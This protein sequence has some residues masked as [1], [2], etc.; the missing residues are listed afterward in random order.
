MTYSE[1]KKAKGAAKAK[2]AKKFIFNPRGWDVFD[3]KTN[4]KKGAIVV[5]VQPHGC[6]KNGTM[7][8]CYVGHPK[9][10]EFIGMV[11]LNSLEA[12]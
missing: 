5:K 6:P 12:K 1:E 9:T 10:G 11:S 7:E 3:P 4:L 2:K 8:M